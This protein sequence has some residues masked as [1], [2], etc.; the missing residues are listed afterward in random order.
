MKTMLLGML[1]LLGA[2]GAAYDS[3]G[4]GIVDSQDRCPYFA[5]ADQRDTDGDGV[6]DACQCGDANGDGRV[7][8]SDIVAVSAMLDGRQAPSA[9]CDANLVGADEQ[10]R[11]E[12]TD[13]AAINAAIYGSC[14]PVCGRYPTP[15][16]GKTACT[17]AKP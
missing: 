16:E 6:G 10:Q 12:T 7:D 3:D 15:P 1:L 11:C 5:A 13:I 2:I 9:L 17:G 8:V 14:F 4:D